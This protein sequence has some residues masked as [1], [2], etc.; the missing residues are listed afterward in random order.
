MKDG[1]ISELER[2][3]ELLQKDLQIAV[4]Q[5]KLECKNVVVDMSTNLIEKQQKTIEISSKFNHA[6]LHRSQKANPERQW[7]LKRL[8]KI[9]FYQ[10][11]YQHQYQSK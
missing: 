8:R 7:Q 4:L 2:Q 6:N 10:R 1:R 9:L 5:T 11:L 3:I